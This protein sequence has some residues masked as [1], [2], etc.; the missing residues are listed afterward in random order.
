MNQ[1]VDEPISEKHGEFFIE[2][3]LV[4]GADVADLKKKRE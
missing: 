3:F 1:V 4:F 2:D